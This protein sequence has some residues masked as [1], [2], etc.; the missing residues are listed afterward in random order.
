MPR[1]A[2]SK[3]TSPNL[4]KALPPEPPKSVRYLHLLKDTLTPVFL[5]IWIIIGLFFLLVIYSQVKQGAVRQLI[6]TPKQEAAPQV[7]GAKETTLEGIG[8]VDIACVTEKV[9]SENIQKAI[10]AKSI[11]VLEGEDK[12]KFESCI[13]EKEVASPSPQ[14]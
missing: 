7:E 12:T 8:K 9:T 6:S 4:S 14:S 5:V 11:D 3:V 10:D 2:A 1:K 13:V